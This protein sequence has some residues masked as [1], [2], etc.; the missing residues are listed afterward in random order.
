MTIQTHSFQAEV[1]KLLKIVAN[2]LYSEKEVFLREL[3]S[4]AS[5]ACDRLRYAALTEPKLLADDPELQVRLSVDAKQKTLTIED[6]GIGM[7]RDELIGNLGT[8]AR[9]GTSAFMSEAS[10]D[11]KKDVNLI[12]Q[13]GVGFYSAFMVADEVT[14]ESRK[15]GESEGWRWKSAGQGEF[16]IEEV[17]TAP[18]RGTRIVLHLNKD[19]K[20]FLEKPRLS[21]IVRT[22]SDHVGLPIRIAGED[23]KAETL[24]K[25]SALWTRPKS[26]ITAE[27]YT[28][29]YHHV[30]HAFDDPW[31]VLHNRVEGRIAYTT[32]LYVPSQRPFDLFNPERKS[33]LK[34]YVN[35]VF[36]TDDC[37]E[38]LPGY[39]R[40]VRGI[41]DSEDLPLN[42]SREM[43]QNNPVLVRIRQAL[44]KRV[45]GELQK[46]ADKATEEYATFWGNFGPVLKEGLYE[47]AANQDK[48]LELARF[49]STAGDGLVSLKDYVARMPE[50]QE[51]IYTISGDSLATLRKSP[52]LEGFRAKGVEV[53]LLHDPVDDFWMGRISEFDSKPFR[54]ITRGDIDLGAVKGGDADKSDDKAE[55]PA[56]KDIGTLI[57]LI[58]QTLGEAV[59]DVRVSKRL[60]ESPVC[61]VA[62]EHDL[63]MHLARVLKA[64][65]QIEQRAPRI[66][67]LNAKHAL[68]RGLAERAAK[69]GASTEMEEAAAL[70]LDQALIVEGEPVAD[71]AAFARRLA[72]VMTRSF[73]AA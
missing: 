32:L 24:N 53:L 68:I 43:L 15:A 21:G 5:D 30:S 33:H 18:A 27:Q 67:E 2:S 28:E 72:D 14:V 34:L 22:Y 65:N 42:V 71:P 10:G 47:D 25:A 54:S 51:A 59:K 1:S 44:V 50:G 66:L 52:Q 35:R 62:D 45:L 55:A 64:H 36:I 41:V 20:E 6:N 4:N 23:G 26:E 49:H 11:E 46:K 19:A 17:D 38:L 13:F 8:I 69:A 37:E 48:L 9:S 60:T 63:D 3:I 56:E 16:T 61:L 12:G 57:A 31:L 58:K 7:S 40:F 73:G 29:F 70:L 39:L